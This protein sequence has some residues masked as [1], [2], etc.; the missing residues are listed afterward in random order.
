MSTSLSNLVNN[1]SDGVQN[2]KCTNCKSY[3]DYITTKDEQQSCT[4]SIFRCF[5]CKKNY[6]KDF[7]KELIKRFANIY[8]FC[9]GD[10]NELILLLRKGIY[11]YEY[12]DS[13]ERYDETSLSGKGVFYNNLNM[14]L[15]ITN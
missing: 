12:M 11:P 8:E 14:E 5:E 3:L 13:W 10:I 9:S 4:Q 15:K 2:N 1:L 7:N 6:E